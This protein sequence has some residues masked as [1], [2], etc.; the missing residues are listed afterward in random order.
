MSQMPPGGNPYA[1]PNFAGGG[2]PQQPVKTYLAESIFCL[3]CC[4]GLFAIPAIVYATKVNSKLAAGDYAGAV[5]ASNNAKKW[6]IIAV[7]IGLVC[8]ALSVGLQIIAAMSQQG[9]M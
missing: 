3:I 7:C 5:E 1:S 8:T 6:C 9:Q 2:A 4:G